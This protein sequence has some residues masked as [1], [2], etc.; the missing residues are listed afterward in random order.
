MGFGVETRTTGVDEGS[1]EEGAVD[2]LVGLVLA[3]PGL[4][5][6]SAG[7]DGALICASSCSHEYLLSLRRGQIINIF[8]VWV[9]STVHLYIGTLFFHQFGIRGS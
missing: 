4:R 7:T 5:E 6:G 9:E 3:F 1:P 2:G 8:L